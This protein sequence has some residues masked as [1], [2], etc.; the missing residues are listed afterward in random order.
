MAKNIVFEDTQDLSVVCTDPAT[1]V[2]G[3]PVIFG[4]NP[5]VALTDEREDGT[6]TVRRKVVAELTVKGVNGSGN[7]AVAVNDEIFY[8]TGDTPKLSKK[9]TGVPFGTALEAIASGSTAT[10]RVLV[11]F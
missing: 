1:P 6:T 5:A 4:V 9:A 7:S 2:S 11:G 8:V 10:I 3:D